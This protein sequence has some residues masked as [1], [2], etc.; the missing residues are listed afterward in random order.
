MNINTNVT[1]SY[2]LVFASGGTNN[3]D[4]LAG[5]I[6][7]TICGIL[8]IMAVII[9]IILFVWCCIKRRS[10]DKKGIRLIFMCT[11]QPC[12]FLAKQNPTG[13]E[14]D[15][16]SRKYRVF[17]LYYMSILQAFSGQKHKHI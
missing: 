13:T 4:N 10:S 2:C 16:L 12:C 9:I 15:P 5:I 3:N 17:I 7:G 1:L 14:L 6:A 8:V 11:L